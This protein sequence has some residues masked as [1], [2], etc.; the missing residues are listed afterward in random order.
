MGGG[1]R[2][3]TVLVVKYNFF[4]GFNGQVYINEHVYCSGVQ[5]RTRLGEQQRYGLMFRCTVTKWFMSMCTATKWLNFQVYSN[6]MVYCPVVQQ[7]NGL[8]FR[9]KATKWFILLRRTATKWIIVQVYC[10]VMVYIFF[11]GFNGQVYINEHVYS[12]GVQQ[13]YGLLFR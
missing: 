9:C 12:I 1:R 13:R 10:N 7:Q 4:H 5:Q 3:Y 11:H 2:V 8:M 6:D